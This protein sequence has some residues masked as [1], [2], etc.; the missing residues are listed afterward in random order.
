M[1]ETK[2]NT[3]DKINSKFRSIFNSTL[4]NIRNQY[5]AKFNQ[6]LLS[7]QTIEPLDENNQIKILL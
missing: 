6:P 4:E 1:V 5:D 3:K 7:I 2:N